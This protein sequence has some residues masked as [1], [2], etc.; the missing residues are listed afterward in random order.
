MSEIQLPRT[1]EEMKKTLQEVF[2]ESFPENIDGFF[3]AWT[4]SFL[5]ELPLHKRVTYCCALEGEMVV[6]KLVRQVFREEWNKL[7]KFAAKKVLIGEI[8][9]I[10]EEVKIGR[11]FFYRLRARG[12][13]ISRNADFEVDQTISVITDH[14][15]EVGNL[16]V[17]I[18]PLTCPFEGL[19]FDSLKS[20]DLPE[21]M[22]SFR[23]KLTPEE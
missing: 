16:I 21:V 4:S 11:W 22:F 14:E 3:K 6:S 23:L 18:K 17:A 12:R 2:M 13:I 19:W 5:P 20:P 9:E 15:F 7:K 8:V 1:K 10:K